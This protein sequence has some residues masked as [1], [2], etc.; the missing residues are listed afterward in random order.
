MAH[1]WHVKVGLMMRVSSLPPLDDFMRKALNPFLTQRK[2][3]YLQ[4]HQKSSR[5]VI[6]TRVQ[7]TDIVCIVNSVSFLMC[8]QK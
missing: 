6:R 3:S 4:V 8:S 7:E 2:S 5:R 1:E